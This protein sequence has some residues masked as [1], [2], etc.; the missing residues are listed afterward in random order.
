MRGN[1][2]YG[3]DDINVREVDVLNDLEGLRAQ[4]SLLD[5]RSSEIWGMFAYAFLARCNTL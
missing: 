3:G 2:R 1:L 5:D 4:I